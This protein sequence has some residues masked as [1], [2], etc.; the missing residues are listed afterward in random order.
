[1]QTA[2]FSPYGGGLLDMRLAV[3]IDGSDHGG[4][5]NVMTCAEYDKVLASLAASGTTLEGAFGHEVDV[6]D[7]RVLWS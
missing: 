3:L 6:Y 1:M 4:T 2:I 7:G 5:I